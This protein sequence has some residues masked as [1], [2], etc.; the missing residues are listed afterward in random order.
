MSIFDN[1]LKNSGAIA[2]NMDHMSMMEP[3]PYRHVP[4]AF[5]TMV[6]A[7]TVALRPLVSGQAETFTAAIMTHINGLQ[8]ALKV[9]EELLVYCDA[10]VDRIR[11][12]NFCFPKWNVAIVSGVDQEKNATQRIA[13]VEALQLTCK[14]VKREPDKK[15]IK[16][17]FLLPNQN[18]EQ[19]PV[20][21][22]VP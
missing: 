11:V 5:E 17:G 10:G 2:N 19:P 14:V 8:A 6:N 3:P 16:I 13:H 1:H 9:D 12:Y 22:P 20:E 21:A 4:S 15:P 18:Q 7:M